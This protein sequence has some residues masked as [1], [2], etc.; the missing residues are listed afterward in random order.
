VY[1]D[2]QGAIDFVHNPVHH[3]LTKHVDVKYHY[4]CQAKAAGVVLVLKVPTLGDRAVS[5]PSLLQ[6]LSLPLM[7]PL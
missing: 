5:S 2:N 7:S 6:A 1:E 3:R 4:I